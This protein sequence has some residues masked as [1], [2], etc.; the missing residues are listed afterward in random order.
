MQFRI[1]RIIGMQVCVT[2]ALSILLLF[3]MGRSAALSAL[4]GGACAFIPALAYQVRA[5]V[6][7]A[8]DARAVLRAQYAGE[9]FK[10]AVTMVMFYVVIQQVKPLNA[11]VLFVTYIAAL[12]CYF[13]ALLTDKEPTQRPGNT[14]D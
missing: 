1:L 14:H 10:L 2:L 7:R 4:G 5:S 3:L 9:G 12:L 13:V 6:A 8:R 11:P